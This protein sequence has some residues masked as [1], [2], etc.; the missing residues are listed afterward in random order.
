MD[1]ELILF[2]RIEVIKKTIKKHGEENFYLSFSGGKDS[3]IL[4][5]L[6]DMALPKNNIPRVFINTGIEYNSIV[7]FVKSLAEKD[8]RIV[9]VN[10]NV[11][12]KKMLEEKGYPFKSKEH[13]LRVYQFNKGTNAKFIKKYTYQTDYRGRYTCPKKLLYQFEEKGKFNFSNKCCDELK[14]KPVHKWAK[15]SKKS[16]VITA[17]R[18]EEGGNRSTIKGCILTN[19]DGKVVKFHPLLVVPNEF[20][21][22]FIDNYKIELCE[23]YYPP[24]DFKRTGCKGC[25]FALDL[26]KELDSMNEFLPVERKQCEVIWKP[27]YDE[28]RRIN[29]RLKSEVQMTI[30]DF[31]GDDKK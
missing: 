8:N 25:P 21:E 24:Y 22:W 30:G 26:Q 1:N 14:K 23:L 17:M 7:K 15:N 2:D 3:T 5:Y 20:E 10:S 31:I 18:K 29:Y 28:Y 27:I 11:N 4:H 16:I 19:K 6:I 12:I 13:S 9:V